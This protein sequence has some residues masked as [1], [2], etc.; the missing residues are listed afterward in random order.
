MKGNIMKKILFSVAFIA[1]MAANNAFAASGDVDLLSDEMFLSDSETAE[2]DAKVDEP[3]E[4]EEKSGGIFGFMRPITKLFGSGN[5]DEASEEIEE[6]LFDKLTRSADEGELESQIELAYIYLYGIDDVEQDF[7]KALHYYTL[8]A[9]QKDPIALNNLGSL[10]FS[11]IGTQRDI[12]KA[13]GLFREAADLGNDNAA[14]NLA[15]IYL[16][17]GKKDAERNKKAIELFEKAH[18]KNNIAKFM[19]GYAYYKGFV[20]PQ[21]YEKAFQLIKAASDSPAQID[22]AQLI[23]ARMYAEGKGTVQNY[24]NALNAYRSAVSQSNM[25]AVMELAQIYAD[26]VMCQKNLVLA[27]SLF[28][29]ASA[30]NIPDAAEKRDALTAEMKLEELTQAQETAQNYQSTPSELT[31]Y[32][33]QTYGSNIRKYIDSNM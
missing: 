16:T 30:K 18:E 21:D 2:T 1:L 9:E 4:K 22:E 33:R 25:E 13:L 23:L 31:S 3:E 5:S 19:L 27:H 6:D 17:G 32:I 20:V 8:A 10:Y 12:R 11:G 15:F 14:L 7:A 24:Q 26:G 29:I 28:N